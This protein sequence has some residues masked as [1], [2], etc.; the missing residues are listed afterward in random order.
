MPWWSPFETIFEFQLQ[1]IIVYKKNRNSL[2][3]ELSIFFSKDKARTKITG[4]FNFKL[5]QPLGTQQLLSTT[6]KELNKIISIETSQ[7]LYSQLLNLKLLSYSDFSAKEQENIIEE[8]VKFAI[9]YSSWEA[10]SGLKDIY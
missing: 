6:V 1:F 5:N 7:N 8:F 9:T 2:F 3:K 4:Y 10:P